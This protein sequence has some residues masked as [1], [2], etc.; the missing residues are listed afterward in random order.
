[1]NVILKEIKEHLPFT[2]I[3]TFLAVVV[4]VL[5]LDLNVSELFHVFHPLHLF[6]SAIVTSAIFYKYKKNFVNAL[7]IGII[8]SIII[9]SLSDIIFPY[10]GGLVFGF[11]MS[12]HLSII[13]EPLIILCSAILGS[14]FGMKIE[15]T[16]FPHFVHVLLS[17][18]ASMF[19]IL[20]FGK[21]F[22]LIDFIISFVIV[23]IAVLIPC[24]LSDIIFSML[25]VGKGK[26]YSSE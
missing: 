19:Y 6:A 14:L 11:D 25:F 12:L 18:F 21:G 4:A 20:N 2:L 17:V 15:A 1:M 5:T 24:C 16:K 22:S 13:E 26:G 7:L 23:F 9:G 10:L 3:A 8:G